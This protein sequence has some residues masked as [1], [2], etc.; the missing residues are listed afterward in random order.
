MA[1]LQ[2]RPRTAIARSAS[3][4]IANAGNEEHFSVEKARIVFLNGAGTIARR[5]NVA[6]SFAFCG[7]TFNKFRR[8]EAHLYNRPVAAARAQGCVGLL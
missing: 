4:N 8:G 5:D 1:A 2:S 3:L 7:A 6:A